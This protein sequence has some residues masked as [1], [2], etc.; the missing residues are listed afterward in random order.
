MDADYDFII[1][2]AGSS[3][4][5]LADRLS[6]EPS[7]RV[8]LIESGPADKSFLIDMPRGIGQLL[9]PGDPHVWSYDV[10]RGGNQ[11]SD[12]WLKGKTLGGSSSVN[13]MVYVRGHP[14][15]YDAWAAEGCVGWS[16]RDVAPTFVAM[17]DHELGSGVERGVGGPLRITV[18]PKTSGLPEA[19]LKA[20]EQAGTAR[21]DDVNAAHDGGFGY[22][23]RTIWRGK[24]QSAAKAFLRPAL[25]RS[26]LTVMTETDARR[27]VFEGRR[28]V[29][30]EVRT[31]GETRV[32]RA[33]RE[34]V[35][36]AGALA[37]PKLLQLSGIG[38]AGR[39]QAVGV[40]TLV[41]A[42]DVGSNLREHF[43]LQVQYRIRAGSLNRQFSGMRLATNLLRYVLFST[44]PMTHAA[45]ELSG[46]VKTRPNLA[47]PDV[48][49]GVGLYTMVPTEKGLSI[50]SE[51]G[52]TI[53][54]Y[55]LQ[56]QSRGRFHITSADPDA[57]PFVEVNYLSEPADREA[58]VSMVRYIRGLAAQ[59]SLRPY[60][61]SELSPGETVQSDEEIVDAHLELGSTAFHVSGTCRM[62]ADPRSV[63]DPQLRVRGVDGLRIADTSILPRLVSG[64]T[65]AVAMMVGARAAEMMLADARLAA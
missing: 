56:P 62:G 57:A 40:E 4:C 50:D 49:L 54:G 35:L 27:I 15:D 41:D 63:V 43:Y 64:N 13:G 37:S 38:P 22:Q 2:G 25:K 11:R 51:P 65:N 39:L 59:P 31:G 18:H 16:W 28:A 30:V 42:P 7:A 9:R 1:V 61:V 19:V 53:G 5:V 46:F 24:R 55:F 8:L 26:N 10:R 21:V 6:K 58:S 14:K 44:G 32:I 48:Q 60:I 3:G 36:A 52:M 33:R 23:P 34:I 47:Q 17:E 45:H 12:L 29:G 20:A